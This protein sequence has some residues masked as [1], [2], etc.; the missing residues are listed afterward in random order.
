MT[1]RYSSDPFDPQPPDFPDDDQPRQLRRHPPLPPWL[2]RKLLQPGEQVVYVAGPRFNPS[3]EKYVTH[4]LLFVAALGLGVW[5][6]GLGWLLNGP[7][8]VLLPVGAA[9]AFVL[10][11]GSIIVL[12]LANGY[13]TRLVA[14]NFRLLMLQG[15]EVYR[16]WNIDDLPRSLVRYRRMAGGESTRP[17]TWTPC[18]PC[19]AA[20]RI[21]SW[22]PSRSWRSASSSAA[23]SAGRTRALTLRVA[24]TAP[25]LRPGKRRPGRCSPRSP[26]V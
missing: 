5:S 7:A 17:S 4:P 1:D 12:G 25:A 6:V 11:F 20:R 23:S 26:V 22:T 21:S 14:T 2:A 18:R 15:Y 3:W 8:P 9:A 19:S 10:F 24:P 16:R 13:F